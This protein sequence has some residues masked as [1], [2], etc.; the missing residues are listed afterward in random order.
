LQDYQHPELV[1]RLVRKLNIKPEEAEALFSALKDFLRWCATTRGP[2]T[3]TPEVDIAWHEF[4]LFTRDYAD[5]CARYAGRFLHHQ[6]ATAQ[7]SAE[8][9]CESCAHPFPDDDDIRPAVH[10]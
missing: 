1:K 4:I 10:A 9:Q 8:C 2:H 5:F 6:P 7:A 3:P